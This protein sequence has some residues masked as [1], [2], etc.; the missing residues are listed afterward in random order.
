MQSPTPEVSVIRRFRIPL[1]DH[2]ADSNDACA[3]SLQLAAELREGSAATTG[4]PSP[5]ASLS[6]APRLRTGRRA[7]VQR[8]TCPLRS[9]ESHLSDLL[10]GQCEQPPDT[11]LP[12]PR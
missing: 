9:S 7:S 12:V 6:P 8:A 2:E 11:G 4:H 10:P 5:Y 3:A 1:T